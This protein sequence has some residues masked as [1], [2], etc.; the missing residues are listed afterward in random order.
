MVAVPIP[1]VKPLI[2][3]LLNAS[4]SAGSNVPPEVIR[5]AIQLEYGSIAKLATLRK[6]SVDLLYAALSRP[7]PS[8]NKVIAESLGC[9]VHRLW[10]LW[11]A[12]SGRRLRSTGTANHAAGKVAHRSQKAASA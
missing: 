9:P 8:G 6:V 12:P 1:D 11:F 5:A 7:Q 3:S 4:V 2:E 10:P